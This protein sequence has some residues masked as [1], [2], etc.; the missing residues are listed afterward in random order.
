M[1]IPPV[2]DSKVTGAIE[3]FGEN[4]MGEELSFDEKEDIVKEEEFEEMYSFQDRDVFMKKDTKE[5]ENVFNE[6]ELFNEELED[7]KNIVF[8]VGF[9]TEVNS[10]FG[11]SNDK[12]IKFCMVTLRST[13][14]FGFSPEDVKS[15][16]SST[17][18]NSIV[19]ICCPCTGVSGH[20][21]G[22]WTSTWRMF[23]CQRTPN[24]NNYFMY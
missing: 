18:S 8:G 5:T 9:G 6:E 13:T 24:G 19:M 12:E 16:S 2:I 14:T 11:A 4:E 15:R 1:G 23:N 10:R 17:Y 21:I 20:L 7:L 3:Y 22:P